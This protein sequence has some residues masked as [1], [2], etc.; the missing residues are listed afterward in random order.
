[1]IGL[2][3][4]RI[5]IDVVLVAVRPRLSVI[6]AV[7]VFEPYSVKVVDVSLALLECEWFKQ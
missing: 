2:K 4:S 6:V 3:Y 1:M 5:S 7:Y